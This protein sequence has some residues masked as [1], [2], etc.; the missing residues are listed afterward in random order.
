[1]EGYRPSPAPYQPTVAAE[2]VAG[3]SAAAA[4]VVVLSHLPLLREALEASKN[5]NTAIHS[6][7][8][9]APCLGGVR[10]K[11]L[12]CLTAALRPAIDL[13]SKAAPVGA[14]SFVQLQSERP[15]VRIR[16]GAAMDDGRVLPPRE[17]FVFARVKPAR[18]SLSRFRH[19]NS[20][21]ATSSDRLHCCKRM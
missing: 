13:A 19:Y 10:S 6:G 9:G 20:L 18:S 3:T 15:G 2:A 17:R 16:R 8:P 4:A 1:V 14:C 5:A 11:R 7:G 12:A 21:E